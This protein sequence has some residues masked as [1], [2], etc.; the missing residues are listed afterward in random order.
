MNGRNSISWGE[1]FELDVQYVETISIG[2]DIK[3]FLKTI[4]SVVAREGINS[5]TS[6]TM[7]AFTGNEAEVNTG[8]K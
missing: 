6:V 4:K 3:I 7:E 8:S 2:L 1:K 5:E